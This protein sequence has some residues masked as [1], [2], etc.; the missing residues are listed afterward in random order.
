MSAVENTRIPNTII[1]K[2]QNENSGTK[3]A[4]PPHRI[5]DT[6]FLPNAMAVNTDNE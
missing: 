2:A 6:N 5:G 3:N 1:G 4:I